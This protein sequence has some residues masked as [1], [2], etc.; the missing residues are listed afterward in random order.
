MLVLWET[1]TQNVIDQRIAQPLQWRESIRLAVF[2]QS[3][4]CRCSAD[5]LPL[6]C[7]QYCTIVEQ[8]NRIDQGELVKV[9]K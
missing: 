3:L 7:R 4:F 9:E 6:P 1:V 2:V 5:V 8:G